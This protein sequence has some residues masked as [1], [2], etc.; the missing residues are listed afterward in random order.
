MH[1]SVLVPGSRTG[2]KPSDTRQAWPVKTGTAAEGTVERSRHSGSP[3]TA[4][5]GVVVGRGRGVGVAAAV[6][7]VGVGPTGVGVGRATTTSTVP[8]DGVG[9]TVGTGAGT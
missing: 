2:T 9:V 7:A 4:G 1:P 8:G 5:G 6:V 3:L